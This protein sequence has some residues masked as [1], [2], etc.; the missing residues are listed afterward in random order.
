MVVRKIERFVVIAY[1]RFNIRSIICLAFGIGLVVSP[2]AQAQ[3]DDIDPKNWFPLELG[4]SWHFK[5][6]EDVIQ[7][8]WVVYSERDTLI[9]GNRWVFFKEVYG[10]GPDYGGIDT[11]WDASVGTWY[12][13]TDDYYV[14]RSLSSPDTILPTIPRSPLTSTAVR[15]DSTFSYF[16]DT[17]LVTIYEGDVGS[18]EDSTNLV[19]GISNGYPPDAG[20]VGY[21]FHYKIGGMGHGY[22]GLVGAR[23]N[24]LE[25][26]ELSTIDHAIALARDAETPPESRLGLEVF[27]N[28]VIGEPTL[29]IDVGRAGYYLIEIYD[30]LGRTHLATREFLNPGSVGARR[31]LWSADSPSGVYLISVTAGDGTRVVRKVT[32]VR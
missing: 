11:L 18:A 26:G 3:F 24:G 10:S 31:D 14:V 9:E 22:L 12:T 21:D 13:M 25:W 29:R 1:R 30:V 15:D 19:L 6:C 8:S 16:D 2:N 7:D 17:L 23:V 28:P 32:L 27:P 5:C 20:G 4:N